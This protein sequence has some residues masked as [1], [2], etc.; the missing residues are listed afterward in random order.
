M[1]ARSPSGRRCGQSHPRA[2]ASD[3]IV[4]AVRETY[5]AWVK[6]GEAGRPGCPKGY[7]TLA[8]LFGIPE[9]TARDYCTYRT[10]RNA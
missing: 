8:L 6:S 9:S 5:E 7:G 4:R 1:I 3:D 2:T 10:R